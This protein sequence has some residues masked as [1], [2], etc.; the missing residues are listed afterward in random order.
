VVETDLA[1][2]VDDDGGALEVGLSQQMAQQRR[3]ATA[4]KPGED[5]DRN[6]DGTNGV[7]A[8]RTLFRA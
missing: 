6:H 7:T 2:L 3:L 4:E 8:T 5:Q 1:E